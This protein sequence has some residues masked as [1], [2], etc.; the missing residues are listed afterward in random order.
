MDSLLL[1]GLL[2]KLRIIFQLLKYASENINANILVVFI[3]MNII[4]FKII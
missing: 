3:K 1:L 2:L 4:Y